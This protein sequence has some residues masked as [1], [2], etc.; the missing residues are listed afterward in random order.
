MAKQT[1]KFYKSANAP[2]AAVVGSVWFD[3]T[4]RLINVRVAE[5]GE[6]Q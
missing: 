4:N 3:T 6:N 5:S 2:A 1:I